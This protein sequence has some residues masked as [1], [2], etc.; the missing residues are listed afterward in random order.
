MMDPLTTQD[1]TPRAEAEASGP[2][3]Q[4]PAKT[5]AKCTTCSMRSSL[6]FEHSVPCRPGPSGKLGPI[7]LAEP[8]SSQR[9]SPT[10]LAS[11][12]KVMCPRGQPARVGLFCSILPS[13]GAKFKGTKDLHESF[14]LAN[15]EDRFAILPRRYRNRKARNRLKRSEKSSTN[16]NDRECTQQG[17]GTPSATS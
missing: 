12:D 17:A 11:V 4:G 2:G 16:V 15:D 3:K 8:A 6:L 9:T 14:T 7:H 5:P 1:A 13:P 10:S